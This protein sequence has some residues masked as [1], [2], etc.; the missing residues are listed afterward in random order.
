[1][2]GVYTF[3]FPVQ[4]C[5]PGN[6]N[7]FLVE[8]HSCTRVRGPPVALHVSQQISSKSWGFAGVAAVSR[9][10][11]LKGPVTPVALER[12]GVSHFKLPLKGVALQRGVAATLAGVAL[13]CAT[14]KNAWLHG[15]GFSALRASRG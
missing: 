4:G 12:P 9:Y 10:T 6:G 8:R 15:G 1:M 13:H 3:F 2:V 7:K 5:C 14:R 11:P